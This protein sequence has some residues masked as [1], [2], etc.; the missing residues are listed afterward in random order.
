VKYVTPCSLPL[1]L[2]ER[3][4]E[5]KG[6]RF[7]LLPASTAPVYRCRPHRLEV[8]CNVCKRWMS[9]GRFNQHQGI[10]PR[11]QLSELSKELPHMVTSRMWRVLRARCRMGRVPVG[12]P[13]L[14]E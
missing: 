10:H 11:E 4:F 2:T 3:H 1:N 5:L 6:L 9:V 8:E 14:R 13:R 12:L 7:R